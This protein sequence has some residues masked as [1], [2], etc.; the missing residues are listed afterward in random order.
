MTLILALL[1][2]ASL[3]LFG[4]AIAIWRRGD[5]QRAVLMAVAAL[6]LLANVAIWTVPIS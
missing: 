1:A 2:S 6:V 3:I 4:G 5:R